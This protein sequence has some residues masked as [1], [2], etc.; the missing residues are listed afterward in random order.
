VRRRW[1]GTQ[2]LDSA[3][4]VKNLTFAPDSPMQQKVAAKSRRR[5]KPSPTTRSTGGRFRRSQGPR[6]SA[7]SRRAGRDA[8]R[9]D[10]VRRTDIAL[11]QESYP[12]HA[13]IGHPGDD[14][15]RRRSRTS[16][17]A[18]CVGHPNAGDK[19]ARESREAR[20]QDGHFEVTDT[21][22][23]VRERLPRD[24]ELE[25]K[26]GRGRSTSSCRRRT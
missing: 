8:L 17:C 18:R 6:V 3:F 1:S 2:R 21:A 4:Y 7:S 15:L 12:T 13:S 24:Q 9:V 20:R 19:K 14:V 16:T 5:V 23:T 26:L 25:G 10:D 11:L 22:A